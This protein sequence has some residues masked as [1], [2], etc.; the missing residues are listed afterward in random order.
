MKSLTKLSIALAAGAALP[1]F[2]SGAPLVSFG[3]NLDLFINSKAGVRYETNPTLASENDDDEG[4]A[5]FLFSPGVE[6]VAGQRGV[7]DFS[8]SILYRHDFLIY[9]EQGELD[10]D[11]ANLSATGTYSSEKLKVNSG[12]RFRETQ[13]N[14]DLSGL[15]VDVPTVGFVKREL[16]SITNYA[17]YEISNK[18]SIGAGLNVST[19][20][21]KD[22]GASYRDYETYSVPV[23]F[24]YAVTPK[25][26]LSVGYRYRLLQ[27]DPDFND[28]FFNVGIHNELA[29]K[30]RGS[31]LIGYQY[32]DPEEK[33]RDDDSGLAIEANI[34][35]LVSPLTTLSVTVSRDYNFSG[36][37]GSSLQQT[38]GHITARH[39]L[40]PVLDATGSVGLYRYEYLKPGVDREDDY[41]NASAGLVYK[42]SNNFHLTATYVYYNNDSDLRDAKFRNNVV[43][44]SALFRY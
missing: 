9:A 20:V 22:V 34:D 36:A 43:E 7:T 12:L 26:D 28:H 17:D 23:D 16:L 25:M 21:Y 10:T 38:G 39:S 3:D 19:T 41:F 42:P 31:I 13:T 6:L 5:I 44:V 15:L 8:G 27:A 18:T 24:Y 35:Y 4:D 11:N 1:A 2:L 29:P 14:Y 32:R 40:T 37:A 30:T 33:G